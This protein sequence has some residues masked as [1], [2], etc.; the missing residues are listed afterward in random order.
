MKKSSMDSKQ[1][2]DSLTSHIALYHASSSSSA[3][4][5]PRT[6]LLKWFKSLTIPQRQSHLTIYDPKFTLIILQMQT[7]TLKHGPSRFI[8]LPDIPSDDNPSLPSICFRRSEGLLVRASASNNSELAIHHAVRLFN[9]GEGEQNDCVTVSEEFV[10]DV[11]RFVKVMDGVSN[12]EFLR[13][14]DSSLGSEWEELPWLKAMGYYGVEAFVANKLELALRL[15]WLSYNG[16]KKRGVKL[17]EKVNVA[18]IG[19]NVYWRKKGCLDWWAAL[20]P[21][22]RKKVFRICLG[23]VAKHLA[24][25]I[26]NGKIGDLVDKRWFFS[27]RPDQPLRD[28]CNLPCQKDAEVSSGVIP[29]PVTGK[30][31]VLCNLL[32]GLIVLQEIFSMILAFQR[33]DFDSENIFYCSLGSIHTVSDLILA[34]LRKLFVVVSSEYIKFELLKGETIPS[35]SHKP[36][37]KL[38]VGNR[39]GRGNSRNSNKRNSLLGSSGP[40]VTVKEPFEESGCQLACQETAAPSTDLRKDT[41]LSGVE[42][43]QAKELV[44]GKIKSVGRKGR[45]ERVKSKNSSISKPVTLGISELKNQQA[46]SVAYS[47]QNEVAKSNLL[48]DSPVFHKQ[49]NDLSVCSNGFKPDSSFSNSTDKPN[50]RGVIEV[51]PKMHKDSVGSKIIPASTSVPALGLDS[52]VKNKESNQQNSNQSSEVASSPVVSQKS[53]DVINSND[54]MTPFQREEGGNYFAQPSP[55]SLG[56]D[57]YEWPSVARFHFPSVSSYVLPAATDRLHLD[58]G[59]NLRN[60]V[61]HSFV[62]T[63]HQSINPSL[64]G[65]RSQIMPR[66]LPMSLDW[67]PMIRSASRLTSSINC[68]YDTGL[69]PE[70]GDDCDRHSMSEEEIEVHTYPGRDYS[71]Y[72]GG[73]VMYWNSSD[74]VASGF[75]RPPSLSSDD[76]SWA[77]HDA[78]LNR[79]IDDMVAFSSSYSTNGLTSPPA[80]TFCSPFD[81]DDNVSGSL[82][83]S[84]QGVI[85][86]QI[87]DSF[88]Y[89]ILRPIIIPNMSRKGSR[90]G[91]RSPCVP[92]TRRDQPRVKRPPSPVVLCVPRPPCPPPPSPVGESKKRRGFPTVRSGSSSPRHWGMRNWYHDETTCREASLCVDGA[93]VIWPSWRNKGLSAS[94]MIQPLSGGML[95]DRLIAISQLPLDQDHPDVAI[96]LQ[97]PDIL[98]CPAR[99]V[100]LCLLHSLLHD[101]IDSFCKQVAAKNLIRVPYINWAVKRVARSLQVLWPRS[102][103]SIYGSNVTGLSLPTSDVDLVVCLPPVRNLE[104]IKEAGILE[105]RNGIKETCLQHA[106]RYLANQE[107][108]KSD[109][110]KTV[111]NTAIPIIMLVAEVPHDFIMVGG[112]NSKAKGPKVESE[113]NTVIG[114]E[115]ITGDDVAALENSYWQK[116]LELNHN[117]G[118]GVKS[119]RLDISFKSTSHTGLQTTELVTS[120]LTLHVL[121]TKMY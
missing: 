48:V 20:D 6:Q 99:K 23:Q 55:S 87:G 49:P 59:R 115:S 17:K 58:V 11:D 24:N 32:N 74:L 51:A 67:P 113:S 7:K 29:N 96:P 28:R 63:R 106:A 98:N 33:S 111:E 57:S 82:V 89:P 30:P 102:R 65:A 81:P 35:P 47:F 3:P 4:S 25:D 116:C 80:G 14:E 5:N 1:L 110:L 34:K 52:D 78:D 22:T 61:Q 31:A 77:W 44:D 9:S 101:E 37:E 10:S 62:S 60:H 121:D 19:A 64:E 8:V 69:I 2:I 117:Q 93:E 70:V 18:G 92:L 46:T 72:F 97:P 71:Q 40:S 79:S 105:G 43:E 112:N 41:S 118:M 90:S 39:R 27:T 91:H 73:G 104:P 95:Q 86:G 84:S 76:S 83:N 120:L 94:P 45:K 100:T 66:N 12:G 119:V 109:S 68:S 26:A 36:K 42:M 15:A 88:Q 54:E 108:V 103:T 56:W 16:A 53:I 107:W 114:E 75:S 13:G 85:E 21:G 50:I 38:G